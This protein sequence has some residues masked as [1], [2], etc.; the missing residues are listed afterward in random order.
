MGR[1]AQ[2]AGTARAGGV[3]AVVAQL[4]LARWWNVAGCAR[5][6][7]ERVERDCGGTI[8]RG[9]GADDLDLA[10]VVGARAGVGDR[11]AKEVAQDA[12][13]GLR[14]LGRDAGCGVCGE[15]RVVPALHGVD[16][17]RGDLCA[18]QQK[19]EDAAAQGVLEQ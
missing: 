15:A 19:I 1:Q 18:A 17:G 11:R 6:E 7:L 16:H 2:A 5:Q 14:L 10:C 9:A 4:V 3:G 13:G 12:L 8:G